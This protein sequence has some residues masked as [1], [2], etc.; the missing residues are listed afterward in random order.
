MYLTAIII[1]GKCPLAH[2]EKGSKRKQARPSILNRI[3][4]LLTEYIGNGK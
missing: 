4:S 2:V 1:V 3:G